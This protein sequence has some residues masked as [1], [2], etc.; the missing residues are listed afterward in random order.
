MIFVNYDLFSVVDKKFNINTY[1]IFNSNSDFCFIDLTLE[2]FM[3][4]EKKFNFIVDEINLFF[5]NNNPFGF[6]ELID[7][8]EKNY[9]DTKIN[10]YINKFIKS[11]NNLF[12]I[13]KFKRVEIGYLVINAID[14]PHKTNNQI[15]LKYKEFIFTGNAITTN[16]KNDDLGFG[17]QNEQNLKWFKNEITDNFLICPMY[18]E[19]IK[20]NHWTLQNKKREK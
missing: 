11:K 3:E 8:F 6:N 2:S 4:F 17:L 14:F 5:T 12:F 20:K 7:Y 9:K 16:L 19:Q 1:F 18:G 10:V 13:D 15:A